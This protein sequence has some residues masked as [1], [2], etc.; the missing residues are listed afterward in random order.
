M[1][2]LPNLLQFDYSQFQSFFLILVRLSGL[3]I[4]AP[5]ISNPNIPRTIKAGLCIFLS[6]ILFPFVDKSFLPVESSISFFALIARE[7]SIGVFIGFFTSLIFVAIQ[8]AGQ[9]MDYQTGFGLVN[10]IDPQSGAQVPL[11]GQFLYLLA[12]LLFLVIGGHHWIIKSLVKSFEAFP[13]GSLT[14][15]ANI[16]TVIND[17]FAKI[18]VLSFKISAPIV[19]AVFLIEMAYGV[20]ARALPQMNI[21]IVGLPLKMGL[22]MFFLM[23]SLPF[24]LWIIKKEF[25]NLFASIDNLFRFF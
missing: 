1:E 22:G 24:F 20:A 23:L 2:N 6:L 25:I 10:I 16:V 5:L 19:A 18:I 9:Y 3:F 17:I 8:L 15:D 7:L 13:L 14:L 11:V 21:L 4:S 12:T